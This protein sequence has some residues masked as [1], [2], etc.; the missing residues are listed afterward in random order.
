M[1]KINN[2]FN[3][4]QDKDI[5]LEI[6]RIK[7]IMGIVFENKDNRILFENNI[8]G[9]LLTPAIEFLSRKMGI[10]GAEMASNGFVSGL[11]KNLKGKSDNFKIQLQCT[12][13]HFFKN[14]DDTFFK[15]VIYIDE[16]YE[17]MHL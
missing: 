4:S 9:K 3:M 10:T 13:T 14:E 12:I 6:S 1:S 15:N 2:N 5:L 16:I 11:E 7:T 8:P 17:I